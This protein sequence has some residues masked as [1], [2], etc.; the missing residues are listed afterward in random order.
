MQVVQI[1]CTN[2]FFV[3]IF[4]KNRDAREIISNFIAQQKIQPTT[5]TKGKIW[6]N[7]TGF[8]EGKFRGEFVKVLG[9]AKR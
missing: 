7:L 6:Q 1:C 8:Y 5:A 2:H 3:K 4:H 9:C